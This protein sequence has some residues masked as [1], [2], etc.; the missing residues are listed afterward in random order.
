MAS[1]ASEGR[2]NMELLANMAIGWFLGF[3]FGIGCSL[4]V[5]YAIYQ[6]GYRKAIAD[7]FLESQPENYRKLWAKAKMANAMLGIQ[8][9]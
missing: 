1:L 5:L 2:R 3:F 4:V 6:G 7:S 8:R 9:F